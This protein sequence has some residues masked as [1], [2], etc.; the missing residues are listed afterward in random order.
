MYYYLLFIFLWV[1]V[2]VYGEEVTPVRIVQA[3]RLSGT[4]IKGQ[5]TTRLS[6]NVV[7]VHEGTELRSQE[8]LYFRLQ[9]KVELT[10]KVTV[11][12]DHKTITAD[13]VDYY[14]GEKKMIARGDIVFTEGTLRESRCRH[15]IYYL[16]T[17]RTIAEQDIVI[18]DRENRVRITG[19]YGEYSEGRKYGYIIQSPVLTRLDD[20]Q[21]E[22]FRVTC[23]KMEVYPDS[24]RVLM[25]DSVT[26]E[27][28]EYRATCSRAWFTEE[29]EVMV[30]VGEPAIRNP[31]HLLTGDTITIF[32]KDFKMQSLLV[33]GHARET[34]YN[35]TDSTRLGTVDS[36]LEGRSMKVS[37]REE[38]IDTAVI[39]KN[40]VSI[41]YEYGPT[42]RRKGKN[43]V[44]GHTI[45]L[46]WE[47]D[48]LK[49]A[50]VTGGA[51]G[52]YYPEKA[53]NAE[54]RTVE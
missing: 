7:V 49:Q 3:D 12:R 44:S 17:E 9:Q 35:Q 46:V 32:L 8:A 11:I 52:G 39:T 26:M 53:E 10:G 34:A 2:K 42:G 24:H 1:F 21:E 43:E 31:E 45:T 23:V 37:F 51:L 29:T 19:G 25:S 47:D 27:K 13:R 41:Y 50:Q 22:V 40:A 18:D 36:R 28:N 15:L 30:L 20:E 6:G 54:Y 38:Q 5:I 48:Q 14:A 33:N 4:N 16:D